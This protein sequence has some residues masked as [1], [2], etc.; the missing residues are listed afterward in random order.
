M[1]TSVSAGA[2]GTVAFGFGERSIQPRQRAR[3]H[4]QDQFI[5]VGDE[6]IDRAIGAADLAR[7]FAAF[8]AP[9]TPRR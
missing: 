9:P 4:A 5:H 6:I 3:S 1:R 8:S 7:Q 2:D